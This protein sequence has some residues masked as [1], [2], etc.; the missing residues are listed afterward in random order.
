MSKRMKTAKEKGYEFPSVGEVAVDD[1][2]VIAISKYQNDAHL[3]AVLCENSKG[4]Y[5]SWLYN[6]CGGSYPGGS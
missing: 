2:E 4:E 1:Y 3:A 5:A 6:A